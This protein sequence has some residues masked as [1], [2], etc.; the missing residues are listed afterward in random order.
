MS[1]S[2]LAVVVTHNRL[3]LLKRCIYQLKNLSTNP[4][5][6]LIIDNGSTDG[7][8][9]FLLK[10]KIDH[11]SQENLGSS[12]GW[13]EG[14]KYGLEHS[15]EYCWLMDDDGYPEKDALFHLV[16]NMSSEISCISSVVLNESD[17]NNFVFPIPRLNKHLNPT[18]FPFFRKVR[19][20]DSIYFKNQTV[21]N[22]DHLFNGCLINM[23]AVR[24]IGNVNKD[25]FI[26][27]DEVDYFYRLRSAGK[28]LTLFKA[29]HFHPSVEDRPYTKT[30]VFYLVRNSLI[31]HRLYFDKSWIR[32]M[33]LILIVLLRVLKR[34]GPGAFSSFLFGSNRKLFFQAIYRGLRNDLSQIDESLFTN[35]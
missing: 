26:M 23:A 9:E 6:I 20:L 2:T 11:I 13:Y 25:Y 4:A 34:N 22:F 16:N 29:K 5:K 7:T 21:Y 30:K 19:R 27:G 10:N 33:F 14:L 1:K 3:E 35:S 31:L 32:N 17:H 8:K 24:K 28:V 12:G 18:L 15:Y